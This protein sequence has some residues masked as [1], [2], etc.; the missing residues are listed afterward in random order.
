[1]SDVTGGAG[2]WRRLT[3]QGWF[4]LALSLMVLL[5]VVGSVVGGPCSRRPRG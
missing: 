2:G 4:F 3:V 1:M 5:V